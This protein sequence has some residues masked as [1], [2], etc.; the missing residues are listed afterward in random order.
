MARQARIVVPGWPHH[1]TQRGNRRQRVFFEHRDFQAYRNHLG[2]ACRRFGAAVWAYCLMPNHVH[3][4]LVPDC[5]AALSRAVGSTHHR[6][7]RR[8]N[9]RRDW[10]GHL[11]QD[12]FYS[13]AMDEGH[14]LAAARYVELNPV[15]AGLVA[16]A[17]EWPW[18]SARHHLGQSPDELLSP[19]VLD[20]LVEDWQAYLRGPEEPQQSQ[21]LRHHTRNGWP[22]GSDQAIASLEQQLGCRLRPRSVGRPR[23]P[24]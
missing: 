6:Y 5:R 20:G 1:V 10:C 8:I 3:L 2:E 22:L 11:W 24:E 18:S 19:G 21:I 16:K 14:L 17:A 4:V 12:R 15:R 7:T 23:R 9:R 13:T